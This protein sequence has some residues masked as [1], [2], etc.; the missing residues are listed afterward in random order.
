MR[1]LLSI[2]FTLRSFC[3]SSVN[4]LSVSGAFTYFTSIC[5]NAP[6]VSPSSI[7]LMSIFVGKRCLKS[8][9]SLHSKNVDNMPSMS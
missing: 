6:W 2:N 3:C 8:A 7:R 9:K 5:V 4:V 1:F